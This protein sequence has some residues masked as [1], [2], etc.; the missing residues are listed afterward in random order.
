MLKTEPLSG[1]RE[2]CL[3]FIH[4]EQNSAFVAQFLYSA[5]VLAIGRNNA[6]F[7]LDGL[8]HHCGNCCINHVCKRCEIA[9]FA[10]AKPIWHGLEYFMLCWL[11]G[12]CQRSQGTSVEASEC[13]NHHMAAPTPEF[14]RKLDGCFVCFGTGIAEEHLTTSSA[15]FGHQFRE[16]NGCF[17]C[18][19]VGK[20]VRHMKKSRCLLRNGFCNYRV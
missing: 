11:S 13:A 12:E 17:R 20:E 19:G 9:I 6:A 18:R 16:S 1:A 8:H 14:A 5:Q 4:N 7:S 2:T 10:V 15:C 3:H